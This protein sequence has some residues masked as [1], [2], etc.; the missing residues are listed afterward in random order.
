MNVMRASA[1]FCLFL[2]ATAWG[3]AFD[4]AAAG[5]W[6]TPATWGGAP[7]DPTP[8]AGDTVTIDGYKVDVNIDLTTVNQPAQIN[9]NGGQ[10]WLVQGAALPS[11]TRTI[12]SPITAGGSAI[13]GGDLH[14]G[15]ANTWMVLNGLL[16]GAGELIKQGP[17]T[18]VLST[19]NY[20]TFTG[21]WRVEQGTLRTDVDG[22]LG[23]S[24]ITVVGGTLLYGA[25]QT[26]GNGPASITVSSGGAVV[27][28]NSR[29]S[30]WNI[31]LNGGK[32]GSNGSDKSTYAGGTITLSGDNL[33]R[34]DDGGKVVINSPMTG[35]GTLSFGPGGNNKFYGAQLGGDNSGYNG[36]ITVPVGYTLWPAHANAL[37][38]GAS[39]CR[40]RWTW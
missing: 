31:T 20:G 6:N 23:N 3:G 35:S 16:S 26:A 10:F 27:G 9:L 36:A 1:L 4:D 7:T 30:A 11:D 39:P 14:D 37:G 17:T 22:G 29:T 21:S 28:G 15:W 25:D 34:S 5:N 24:A 13:I 38:G 32:I 2:S 19:N 12:G 18:V 8:I 33:F 40:A